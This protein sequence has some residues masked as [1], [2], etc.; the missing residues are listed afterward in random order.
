[1]QFKDGPD[2]R[3]SHEFDENIH[4]DLRA[5]LLTLD[6]W[7]KAEGLPELTITMLGRTI[8]EEVSIYLGFWVGLMERLK[9]GDETLTKKEETLAR[10]KSKKTPAVLMAEAKSL[11]SYHFCW[12][13][14]DIRDKQYT[15][16]QKAE[17]IK[18]IKAQCQPPLWLV[19]E[20]DI[21]APHIHVQRTDFAWRTKFDPRRA[22]PLFKGVV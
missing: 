19:L 9:R 13:A 22:P 1:M 20:H 21:T 12:C 14:A 15:H 10:E 2:G 3:M 4:P 7:L 6:A 16:E 17:V 18:W 8:D 11:F 5:F